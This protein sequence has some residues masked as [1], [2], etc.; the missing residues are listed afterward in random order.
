MRKIGVLFVAMAAIAAQPAFAY[1]FSSLE[2][3]IIEALDQN[4]SQKA[5]ELVKLSDV[6]VNKFDGRPIVSYIFTRFS[7]NAM[8]K[9]RDYMTLV[10]DEW[11]QSPNAR[12]AETGEPVFAMFCV[13]AVNPRNLPTNDP[14]SISDDALLNEITNNFE[15]KIDFLLKHSA[16]A[17]SDTT[18]KFRGQNVLPTCVGAYEDLIR[19]YG[20]RTALKQRF[21]SIFDKLLKAG[22]DLGDY[23]DV[24]NR[25]D[26]YNIVFSSAYLLDIDLLK[27]A[28]AHKAYVTGSV[29]GSDKKIIATVPYF[30][31]NPNDKD[32]ATVRTY[33]I[34]WI[35][36][37]GNVK[38]PQMF[39]QG[40]F[41]SL[42]Q[43]ALGMGQV[44]YAKMVSE[45]EQLQPQQ[46]AK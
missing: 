37:G 34:E 22:A 29:T 25:H 30:L 19:T 2:Y 12:M 11:K 6:N 15:W 14:R 17:K 23:W 31:P 44:E 7:Q 13:R 16:S 20:H 4:N 3:Q 18:I 42:K 43:R 28:A 10:F 1:K 38:Q 36:L 46:P 39:S 40:K 26:V 35:K 21:F 41:E 24:T 5:R 9:S 33:L 27:Y 45:L 32:V 8:Y